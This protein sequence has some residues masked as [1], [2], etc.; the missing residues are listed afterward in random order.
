MN[1]DKQHK[2]HDKFVETRHGLFAHKFT[3]AFTYIF[4]CTFQ[5]PCTSTCYVSCMG[6]MNLHRVR[7]H[8][9]KRAV[10]TLNYNQ[11]EK[12]QQTSARPK[13]QSRISSRSTMEQVGR[14]QNGS[15]T[16][17]LPTSQP[18]PPK[19]IC[20]QE[21]FGAALQPSWTHQ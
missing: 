13:K 19:S 10:L 1:S 16:F 9:S 18:K 4:F 20:E 21:L 15:R 14:L 7:S 2:S 17:S 3:H 12:S 11:F 5:N 8:V 6:S